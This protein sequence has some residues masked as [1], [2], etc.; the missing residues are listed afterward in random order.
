MT[1]LLY[2]KLIT[3]ITKQ[4]LRNKD[5]LTFKNNLFNVLQIIQYNFKNRRRV[6]NMSLSL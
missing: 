3:I 2:V 1:I 6:T 4:V 5:E